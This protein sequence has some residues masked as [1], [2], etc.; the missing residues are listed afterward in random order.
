VNPP[1]GGGGSSCL[2]VAAPACDAAPPD[3]GA[4]RPWHGAAPSGS[5]RHRGHDQIYV[6][7]A[8][9]WLIARFA[10]GTLPFVDSP[11]VDEEVDIY[12]SRGCSDNWEKLGTVRT[13]QANAHTAV[14]GITDN[15]GRVYFEIPADKMLAR[16]RHRVHLVVAGDLTATDLYIERVPSSMPMFVSDVDGTLTTDENAEVLASA[17]GKLPGANPDAAKALGILAEKGYRPL[18]LTARSDSLTQRTRDFLRAEGF[19][20]GI[21]RTTTSVF[22]ESGTAAGMYKSGELAGFAMKGLEPTYAF[23]NTDSDAQAYHDDAIA[24]PIFFKFTDSTFNGRRIEAYSDVLM[25]FE[26]LPPACP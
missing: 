10:Y 4:A 3:P 8:P 9:Q 6:D 14:E 17:M 12:L 7:D 20:P 5:A 11:L 24:N 21:V 15:G 22:G 16:G 26:N 13:T 2:P 23:G 19:P 25:E 1:D 18:Y